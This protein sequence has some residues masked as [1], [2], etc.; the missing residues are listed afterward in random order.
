MTVSVMPS[1]T[2]VISPIFGIWITPTCTIGVGAYGSLGAGSGVGKELVVVGAL[3]V[4]V[5]TCEVEGAVVGAAINGESSPDDRWLNDTA[6]VVIAA[7]MTITS[8]VAS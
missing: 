1:Y 5:V 4:V 6:A 3:R 8:A 2:G 7:V